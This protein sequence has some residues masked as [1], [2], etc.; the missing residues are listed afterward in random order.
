MATKRL[1]GQ[2]KHEGNNASYNRYLQGQGMGMTNAMNTFQ[3]GSQNAGQR[4][5]MSMNLADLGVGAANNM[6]N[7]DTE[8]LASLLISG[9]GGHSNG[10]NK[11]R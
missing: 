11:T 4:F 6:G 2:G 5:G 10:F 7:L 8:C 9:M 3:S 1:R